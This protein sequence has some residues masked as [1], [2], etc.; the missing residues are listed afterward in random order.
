[1][2]TSATGIS[3]ST[4]PAAS[5]AI[6]SAARQRRTFAARKVNGAAV[7]VARTSA[8]PQARNRSGSAAPRIP[9][10]ARSRGF[11]L[12]EL[13][14]VVTI[15]G[16]FAGAAVLSL[17]VLGRDRDSEREALRL[18]SLLDLVHEEA[19]M[20]SRDFGVLFGEDGYRFYTYDYTQAK[21]VEPV[22]D[23]LF[24]PHDLKTPLSLTLEVED[25]KLVLDT[26]K[27]EGEDAEKEPAPQVVILSSG[28]MTP[29]EAEIRRD[30]RGGRFLLTAGL[31]GRV[32]ITQ[33]GFDKGT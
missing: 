14:V 15:I 9:P 27:N 18:K 7:P 4:A 22:G 6:G 25:R 30:A 12:L 11:S 8:K 32:E 24:A 20:Q 31:D 28:E 5:Q 2:P 16:I 3:I 29:F 33:D 1:M 10:R 13:L 23:A 17:G 26:P 21:W 19:V